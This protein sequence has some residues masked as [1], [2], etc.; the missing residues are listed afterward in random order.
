[1]SDE[2]KTMFYVVPQ[3]EIWTNKDVGLIYD[4]QLTGYLIHL[5]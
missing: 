3:L 4:V 5:I 2:S 1:M